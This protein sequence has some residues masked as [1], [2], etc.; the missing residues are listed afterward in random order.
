MD[1]KHHIPREHGQLGENQARKYLEQQG[2]IFVEQNIR[3]PFG[4]ID[5]IMR[6]G[7]E[8]IF[9]EVKY[10]STSHFGGAVNALSKKQIQRLRRSAEHY[11]QI[12]KI[13][14]ICRF[15]LIAIDA[16]QLDWLKNAF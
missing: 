7:K 2:L 4:E 9:V 16:G 15:D 8:L 10:R 6:Q 5:L 13:D 3:Y 12:K 14:V 1:D 11:M